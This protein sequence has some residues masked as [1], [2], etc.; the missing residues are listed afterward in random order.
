MNSQLMW[1][2]FSFFFGGGGGDGVIGVTPMGGMVALSPISSEKVE[3]A[4]SCLT[5]SLMFILL[6]NNIWGYRSLPSWYLVSQPLSGLCGCD[7][8]KVQWRQRIM[9]FTLCY[10]LCRCLHI[11]SVAPAK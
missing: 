8:A 1:R 9:Q 10:F 4:S 3:V 6:C 2:C 11:G 5:I 7:M